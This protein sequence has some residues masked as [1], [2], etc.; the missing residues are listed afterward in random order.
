M[1][2]SVRVQLFNSSNVEILVGPDGILGTSDDATNGMLTNLSG[3]YSFC[4][5]PPGQFRV[6][7]TTPGGSSSTP[8]SI[9]PDDN[10]DSDDNGFPGSAPFALRTVSGL[11]TVLPGSTGTLNNKTVTNSTGTTADPTI[12]FG[13]VLPPT[14]IQLDNF[15]VSTDGDSVSLKWSTGGEAGNLGFNLYR[16]TNGKRELINSA[17]IAGSAVRTSANLLA[18]G[19]NYSWVDKGAKLNSVYYLEDIDIEGNRTIYGPVTPLFK[20]SLNKFEQNAILLS[21]LS[22]SSQNP[23]TQKEFVNEKA[24]NETNALNAPRQFEIAARGGVKISVNHDGWYK[25]PAT[26]LQANGFD[27]NSNR[28]FWQLFVG[29]EEVAIKVAN[30]GAVE[31]FGRGVDTLATDRQVYY[32]VNGQTNGARLTEVKSGRAGENPLPSYATT[33]ER[34]DRSIY[35]SSVL[36]GEANNWFGALVTFN[37]Q[38]VQSLS[39]GNIE[40]NSQAR[41]RVKLQGLTNVA[42]YVNVRFN[43][44]DLGQVSLNNQENSEFEFDVPAAL[45]VEG[46]NNVKLQSAGSSSDISLVDTISLSYSRLYKAVNNQ[47]RFSVPAGRSVKVGGFTTGKIAINEIQ[48]GEVGVRAAAFVE[49]ANNEFSFELGA[50]GRNREFLAVALLQAEQ[51]VAVEP[52]I[53]S[54]LNASGNKADLV[55]VAPAMFQTQAAELAQMRENQGLRSQVV[56]AEDVADEFGF[57]ILTADSIKEFLQNAAATWRVKPRYVILFGDSS[58]DPRNYLDQTNHNVIPTKL[59]DTVF[60][61]T[62]S[63]SWMADFDNNGIEDISIGRLSATT[64]AEADVLI[65]KL[66]R[67]DRQPNRAE[68]TSVLT[69]DHGFE[70]Y[71]QTLQNDLPSDVNVTRIDRSAMTDAEMHRQIMSKLNENPM[72]AVYTGHGSTS[73]WSNTVVFTG[74]DAANLANDQFGFYLLTTCLNGYTHGT[75][76]DSLAEAVL[77]NRNGG[78][79]AVWASSGTNFPDTQSAASQAAMHLIFNSPNGQLRIGDIVREAK[80]ATADQDVRRSYLL[81]GDPTLVIR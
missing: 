51:T 12:D 74:T 59:V 21:D 23:L 52:N 41:L 30:D 56:L 7:V 65:S 16:E 1:I 71:S 43:E 76:Y 70:S 79:I 42:H 73:L 45:L 17:P 27:V 68:R 49:E 6:V 18:S 2:P 67:Y 22:V 10:V 35:I 8:T 19:E 75:N 13:F 28:A 36:N 63:D 60:M 3:N 57:G 34:K 20:I 39:L 58:Y 26:A 46:A 81:L 32:L 50:A 11:V 55:I 44:T 66:V 64:G 33:A 38:T 47:I 61:E 40:V 80:T 62:S 29:G 53:P 78:A 48:N 54:A 37:S 15:T 25:V 5:L 24:E 9:N 69:A 77:K 31:F 4:S 72:V 14:A